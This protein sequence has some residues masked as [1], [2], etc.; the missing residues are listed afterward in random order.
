MLSPQL[1]KLSPPRL[2]DALPRPRLFAQLDALRARHPVVWITA[3]PGAGKT[4]LVASYLE[5]T[6]TTAI[7]FQ[8]DDA[9]A[10]PA[11]F[12]HYLAATHPPHTDEPP[13]PWL[14]PELAG[15]IPRFA[16]RFF[17]AY[18]ARL[19]PGAVLVTCTPKLVRR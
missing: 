6:G 1:P 19:A 15:D 18:F 17:R 5:H 14:A 12:F 7:W 11:T 3:P 10:D 16:R 2:F 9:D 13:L 8:V 4:T